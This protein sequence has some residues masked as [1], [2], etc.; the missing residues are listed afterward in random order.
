[1]GAEGGG[2]NRLLGERRGEGREGIGDVGLEGGIKDIGGGE[3]GKEQRPTFP[4]AQKIF[5]G[6]E[7]IE[8][9]EQ[10]AGV[11]GVDVMR[12]RIGDAGREVV[13]FVD[14]E[15]RTRGIEAGL[16]IKQR[17]V[18]GREDVVVIA[19]PDVVEGEGGA[20]DLVG[21]D[22]RGLASSAERGEIAGLVF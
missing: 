18:G 11:G 10:R 5:R 19:D 22:A 4:S 2:I 15:Q 20:R 3:R 14:Q 9:G 12:I 6:V 8:F 17:A 16:I 13:R 21:T 1:M 7:V